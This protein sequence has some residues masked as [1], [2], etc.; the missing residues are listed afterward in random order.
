MSEN[1]FL[2]WAETFLFKICLKIQAKHTNNRL[3]N[4]IEEELM[5]NIGID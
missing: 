1:K 2:V 3:N 5:R 4:S